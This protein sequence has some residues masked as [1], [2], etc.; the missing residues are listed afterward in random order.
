MSGTFM[1]KQSFVVGTHVSKVG[2]D[3]KNHTQ[4]RFIYTIKFDAYRR[5][6]LGL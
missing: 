5:L 1:R 6:N 4:L 3:F 2:E